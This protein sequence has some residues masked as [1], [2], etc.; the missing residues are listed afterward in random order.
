MGIG[1]ALSGGVIKM[2]FKFNGVNKD[3]VLAANQEA[4]NN[5]TYSNNIFNNIKTGY[6]YSFNGFE[7]NTYTLGDNIKIPNSTHWTCYWRYPETENN[8]A[9]DYKKITV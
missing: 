5:V 3:S 1:I 7:W 6:Q 2:Y 9:S 8:L 4:I